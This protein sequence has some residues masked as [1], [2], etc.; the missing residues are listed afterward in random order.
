MKYGSDK[1]DTKAGKPALTSTPKITNKKINLGDNFACVCASF[2]GRKTQC[3]G[4]TF[5]VD[6]IKEGQKYHKLKANG[7]RQRHLKQMPNDLS[8]G[9][10]RTEN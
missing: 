3:H 2:P 7:A 1:Q 6:V 10:E 9:R 8:E 4:M 5:A